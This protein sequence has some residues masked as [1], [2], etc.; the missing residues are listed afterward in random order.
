MLDFRAFGGGGGGALA[1]LRT[2]RGGAISAEFLWLL[3][4]GLL[5]GGGGGG[6][7]AV[8]PSVC[9]D[10]ELRVLVALGVSGGGLKTAGCRGEA[11]WKGVSRLSTSCRL[12]GLCVF[13]PGLIVSGSGVF[14]AMTCDLLR[15]QSFLLNLLIRFSLSSLGGRSSTRAPEEALRSNSGSRIDPSDP[16]REGALSEELEEVETTE[17]A[18]EVTDSLRSVEDRM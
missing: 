7:E 3:S 12:F 4:Y 18:T 5:L 8:S 6:T 11:L 17:E 2:G 9:K 14:S 10:G 16:G 1:S 13:L 15:P